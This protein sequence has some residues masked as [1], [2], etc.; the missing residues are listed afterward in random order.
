M[1]FE[2]LGMPRGFRLE[3]PPTA[4]P[5]I[6]SYITQ[7]LQE[8]AGQTK[9]YVKEELQNL[10]TTLASNAPVTQAGT[11]VPAPEV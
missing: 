5:D 6:Q 9:G 10:I 8:F 4:T 1:A 2:A 3:E 11:G 7:Q